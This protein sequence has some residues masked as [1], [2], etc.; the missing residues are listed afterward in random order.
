MT[1]AFW[2]APGAHAPLLLIGFGFVVG[3]LLGL[4][5]FCALWWNAR[6]Y[7]RGSALHALALHLARFALLL[8]VLAGLAKLG[9]PS[10]LAGALGL[11]VSRG[12]V[13]RR[14]GKIT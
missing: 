3:A 12:L 1:Q 2:Q 13:M 8:V 10:L 4:L 6:L 11:L 14:F 7:G 9:A 5:H